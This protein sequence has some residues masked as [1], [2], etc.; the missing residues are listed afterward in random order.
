MKIVTIKKNDKNNN[1]ANSSNRK[2]G[3]F[4]GP[5]DFISSLYIGSSE[6]SVFNNLN[7]DPID[8]LPM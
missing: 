3:M 2:F 7:L 8:Q 5:D 4:I 6:F 1:C